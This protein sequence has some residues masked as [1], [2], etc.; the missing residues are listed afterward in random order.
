MDH[1]HI[2]NVKRQ[3]TGFALITIVAIVAIIALAVFAK[4]AMSDAQRRL[5]KNTAITKVL[6]KVDLALVSYV[7]QHRR[8]PCPANGLIASGTANVGLELASCASQANGVLPWV[9][10]GLSEDESRDPWGARL[11]YRVDPAL[12]GLAPRLMDMSNCDVSGTGSVA[13]GGACRTPTP[14]C[15]A[16]P[17]TCTS[18]TTFL[19]GKGLDV[20]DG[21]GGA[22][23]W[24]T[25]VN[26]RVLGT[27]AA[28]VVISHGETGAGAYNAGGVLQPGTIGPIALL[29]LPGTQR[30]GDDEMPNLA[31][32][33]LALPATQATTY[34][35]ATLNTSISLSHF[36]DYLSHPSI[37]EVLKKAS[38]QQRVH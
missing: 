14:T 27:G 17:T 34:R 6:S 16:N 26:N 12:T 9:T 15:V 5:G 3:Q 31:D 32:L 28:Y 7:A 18:P 25:R 11:T 8:L 1:A 13:G 23:G 38:L 21:V 30:A 22:G 35:A 29:P 36:D 24:A 19:A 10:L 20:W 33:P 4:W 2:L 37:S